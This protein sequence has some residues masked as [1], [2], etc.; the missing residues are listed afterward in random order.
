M[1]A[2]RPIE[3]DERQKLGIDQIVYGNMDVTRKPRPLL[4][5]KAFNCPE[6]SLPRDAQ[7]LQIV[8]K[9]WGGSKGADKPVSRMLDNA[10]FRQ[11]NEV[12]VD[13]GAAAD[14]DL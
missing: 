12:R 7:G 14:I 6:T 4:R 8:G 1:S 3:N 5:P 13:L 9:P 10:R 2:L 11:G